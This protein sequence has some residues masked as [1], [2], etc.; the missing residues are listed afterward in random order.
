[1]ELSRNS[2]EEFH[3]SAQFS[4]SQHIIESHC[5]TIAIAILFSSQGPGMTGP[6]TSSSLRNDRFAENGLPNESDLDP[7][8]EL[9][10]P[11]SQGGGMNPEKL[12]YILI[13]VCC[14]LSIL[15]LIIVAVSI[16]YKT[17]TH[18]RS[19]LCFQIVNLIPV[20]TYVT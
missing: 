16:G 4:G 14:G 11:S 9:R 12:A 20:P 17:E 2:R 3:H 5:D 13:G 15:C 19:A 1:M 10:E 6:R 7:S 8:Q 18:Y